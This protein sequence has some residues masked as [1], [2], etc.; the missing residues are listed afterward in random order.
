MQ[1]ERA[2][3]PARNR[4]PAGWRRSLERCLPAVA[5]FAL[6]L[7]AFGAE[8]LVEALPDLTF[9]PRTLKIRAGDTVTFVNRG[10][11]H[12][13]QTLSGPESFRCAQGC[14]GL[15]GDGSPSRELWSFSWTFEKPGTVE[16]TCLPHQVDGMLGT[17]VVEARATARGTLAFTRAEYRAVESSGEAEI[18]VLRSG[19]DD[20]PVTVD[21]RARSGSAT[22][23]A[24]FL[25]VSGTLAW[26]DGA[27]GERRFTVPVLDDLL[28]EEDEEIELALADPS[29]GAKL[30]RSRASLVIVDDDLD[31]PPCA[32]DAG[33]LC[34]G[35]RGRF[36]VR[37]GWRAPD[38]RQGEGLVL[39]I[40]QRDSGLFYFFERSNAEML[41]KVLDGCGVNDSFWVYFA[42][43]TDLAF[44]LEV[45][46]TEADLVRRYSNP[47]GKP[48]DTVA[49]TGAFASC[50]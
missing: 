25:A 31:Y 7:P 8:H 6:T 43:T 37:V 27:G 23:D 3:T 33:T 46:D 40:G 22:A 28:L 17:I 19:G 10:G 49:D 30:G 14:D 41:V 29:G 18:A 45:V 50:P 24:D 32:E 13:V 47:Q 44:E 20:G 38:D 48:A 39:D 35:A 26:P 42:A 16:Y 36:R 34:L 5:A 21:Y 9:S 15:G 11:F 1:H 4:R 12:H 2:P